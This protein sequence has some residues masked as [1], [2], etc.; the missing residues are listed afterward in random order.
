MAIEEAFVLISMFIEEKKL[1]E[2]NS[3]Q[4]ELKQIK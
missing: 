2:I 3:K 4:Q 1:I